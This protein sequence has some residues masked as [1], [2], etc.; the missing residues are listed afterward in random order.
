MSSSD[1]KLQVRETSILGTGSAVPPRVLT[2]QELE[3]LVD[4]SDEWIVTRTG[5]RERRI[6]DDQTA[7]SDLATIAAKSALESAGLTAE[8]LDAI[9]VCTVTGDFA[10][11]STAC[12][13][14]AAI[15]APRAY[16]MDLGAAC[17][18]FIYGT[19]VARGLIGSHLAEH[20]LVIGV[21]MLSKFTNWKD[22]GTCILF[23][24]AAGAAVMG[25]ANGVHEIVAVYV[26]ADGRSAD[27]I[28]LPG[29]GSRHPITHEGI[30]QSQHLLRMKGNEVFKLGVRGM[31]EA[32]RRALDAAGVSPSE[33]SLLVPHQ[34]NLRII[35][36]T[37]QRLG[38]PPEKVFI[39]IH[40]YGNT[41]AA[42]VPLAL[43]EAAREGRLKSG[44]LVLMVAF[45]AG[46]TW[47][48]SLVRW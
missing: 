10:F 7:G 41:S 28:D 17:S 25:P 31:E 36:A 30:D 48:A 6:A 9:V 33:V 5:I 1:K 20:V 47:G 23:G 34:A 22:R 3:A 14:Q 38:L 35:D 15:G 11:P 37:A 29:G 45:G 18:G 43:D 12:L 32:C 19:Q 4:T 46:L 8:S 27:L 24:D 39:N 13:V 44:D 2:N 42:S 16:A 40:K 26:G 21:E